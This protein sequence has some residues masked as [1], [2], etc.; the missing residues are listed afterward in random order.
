MKGVEGVDGFVAL[1]NRDEINMLIA[2]LAGNLGARRVIPLVHR[3]EYMALLEALDLGAAV[4]PR[5]SAANAILRY[6]R[7]GPVASVATLKGSGAEALEVVLGEGS[8]LLGRPLRDARFP[9]GALLG[10][11]V[12]GD[13]VIM[14]R[15]D[16]V[17]EAGDRAVFLVLPGA[18]DT[19][20]PFFR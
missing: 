4:S 14:P 18:V 9:Q 2:L 1:T 15:G 19:L 8:S 16:T 20:A 17:V 7:K 5:F 3:T 10:A 11:L 13:R 6:V 12:R